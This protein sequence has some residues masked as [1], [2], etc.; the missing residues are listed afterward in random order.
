MQSCFSLK[1]NIT[2]IRTITWGA[3]PYIAQ[4]I[5]FRITSHKTSDYYVVLLSELHNHLGAIPWLWRCSEIFP[6]GMTLRSRY[7]AFAI[8]VLVKSQ[9]KPR[10]N[11]NLQFCTSECCPRINFKGTLTPVKGK[12]VLTWNV[13]LW[14]N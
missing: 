2:Y 11:S 3:I 8:A 13:C 14:N 1:I 7:T 4:N 12:K 9:Q 6:L 10:L 5:N